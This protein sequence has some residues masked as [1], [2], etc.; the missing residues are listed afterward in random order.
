MRA[1]KQVL[2]ATKGQ[3]DRDAQDFR[4]G[5]AM[6]A[7]APRFTGWRRAGAAVLAS[8]LLA[9]QAQ[10]QDT[11]TTLATLNTVHVAD[12]GAPWFTSWFEE[13][14]QSEGA[15]FRPKI[16]VSSG[17]SLL[18]QVAADKSSI[19]L[20]SQAE[21]AAAKPLPDTISSAASGLQVCAALVVR[22]TA[23]SRQIGDLALLPQPTRIAA[24]GDTAAIL[25]ALLGAHGF[26][27]RLTVSDSSV[28][29]MMSG[30]ASGTLALAALPV[31]PADEVQLPDNAGDVRFMELTDAAVAAT[32]GDRF[33]V[34]TYSTNSVLGVSLAS[35]INTVCDDIMIVSSATG[36]FKPG[37]LARRDSTI[38][39]KA[40]ESG[41]LI[42]RTRASLN[43][44]WNVIIATY[45]GSGQ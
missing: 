11:A 9:S 13:Q 10:S 35:G 18:E 24:T 17:T 2:C 43:D 32:A 37:R 1:I 28:P 14:Q 42:E 29:A 41:G 44:L 30:L 5:A 26:D 21:L 39:E 45:Q 36:Q 27:G 16:A 20:L 33:A 23:A 8:C 12:A 6:S 15:L 34:S 4:V 38:I 7:G 31:E 19:G 25:R 22:D 3:V 40:S